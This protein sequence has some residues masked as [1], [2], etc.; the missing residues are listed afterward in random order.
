MGL[1]EKILGAKKE[2]KVEIDNIIYSPLT[3]VAVPL[4][5][6]NDLVFSEEMMGKGAAVIP[7]IGRVVAPCDGE[8]VSVFRTLHAVT[9]K[10]DNGAEIIIHV[11]LETV[12]L[13]GKYYKSHVRDSQRVKKGDLLLTFDLDK[14]KEEGYDVITPVVVAN[15]ADYQSVDKTGESDVSEGDLLINLVK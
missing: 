13:D 2:L 12:A 3:G 15:T 11:G 4:R 8:V 9:F 7:T 10:A 1:F 5:E 14:I 6:V